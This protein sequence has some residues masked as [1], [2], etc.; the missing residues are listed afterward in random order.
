VTARR[1]APRT[2]V[3]LLVLAPWLVWAIVRTF[4]IEADLGSHVVPAMAFTP[5]VA[6]TTIVP[7]LVALAL[8]RW[9]VAAMGLVVVLVFALA[10]LPRAFAGPRARVADGVPVTVMTS[11]LFEGRGDARTIVD[12]VRRH[13]VGVLALEELTDDEVRR[14]DAAGLRR[15]LPYRD[16]DTRP[17]FNASGTGLFSR[18]PIRRLKPFN[19]LNRNAEP[20]ALVSVPG[21]PDLDVHTVHPPPPIHGWNAIWTTMLGELPL[22]DRRAPSLRMLVGDF[23]ATL[24]H[25]QL[26]RLLGDDGYV[27]AADATGEGFRTTWPAGRDFPPELTIDHVLV[28]PRIAPRD[29]KVHLVPR[30]DHRAV[31]ADLELPRSSARSG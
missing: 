4:G 24:D 20:R 23:N 28:D 19:S 5:Y 6:A 3:A 10:V 13:R 16:V 15:L 1:P 22:P 29:V 11:N 31:I 26:R 30:S 7:L 25:E 14:L 21:A 17:L 18:T 8:R 9:L 12:L 2:V 27:D